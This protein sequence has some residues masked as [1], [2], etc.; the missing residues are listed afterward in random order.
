MSE[1]TLGNVAEDQLITLKTKG[2]NIMQNTT[3]SVHA[4]AD[5]ASSYN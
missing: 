1:E 5:P 3:D 2:A 4:L